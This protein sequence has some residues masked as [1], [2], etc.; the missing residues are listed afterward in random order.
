MLSLVKSGAK[1]LSP[2]MHPYM[3][4]SLL[5]TDLSCFRKNAEYAKEHWEEEVLTILKQY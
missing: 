4:L 1:L 2:S 5:C 3:S